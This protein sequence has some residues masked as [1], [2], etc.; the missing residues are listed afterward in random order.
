MSLALPFLAWTPVITALVSFAV[1]GE[2][3]GLRGAAGIALVG[4][5]AFILVWEGSLAGF[6]TVVRRER[7]ILLILAVAAIYSVTS[8]LGK[9]GVRYSSPAFFG[10]AYASSVTAALA[11]LTLFRGGS[12]AVRTL[13]PNRWFL[14]VGLSSGVM[15]ALHFAALDLTQVAYMISV[16]RS[17]LLF[18]VIL[19]GAF[20]G[21]G[22]RGRRLLGTAVMSV[23]MFL[24]TARPLA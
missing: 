16:K 13:R 17:S 11:A 2:V 1:L 14:A 19:G 20:F 18:S 12:D 8:T 22:R 9:L 24:I 10:F 15:I 23:G 4:A 21:E 5:G 6:M 7:G 3:P